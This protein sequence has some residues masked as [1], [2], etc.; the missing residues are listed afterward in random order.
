MTI[1]VLD[2]W[3]EHNSRK[4]PLTGII[5]HHTAGGSAE[6]TIAYLQSLK[7]PHRASYHY[8]PERDGKILK[9]VP[10]SARA[11]HAGTSMGKYGADVNSQ[12]VGISFANDGVGEKYPCEQV[13]AAHELVHALSATDDNITWISTHRL[14]TDRKPDPAFFDF[15]EFCEHHKELEM[16]RYEKLG[17]DW[18]G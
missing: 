10:I 2:P 9:C 5:L 15:K 1:E 16:W 3:L 8:I 13:Q 11:W 17:R 12:T 14:I 4:K 7:S 6:S 18:N